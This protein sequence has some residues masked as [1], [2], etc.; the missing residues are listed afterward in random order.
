MIASF[1]LFFT[2]NQEEELNRWREGG[3]KSYRPPIAPIPNPPDPSEIVIIKRW[4][5]DPKNSRWYF[6]EPD[7]DETTW[8]YMKNQFLYYWYSM[9]N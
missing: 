7:E 1:V 4:R 8:E 6:Y 5:Y 9:I 2:M 3:V